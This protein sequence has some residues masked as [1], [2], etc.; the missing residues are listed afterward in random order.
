MGK[1]AGETIAAEIEARSRGESAPRRVFE[2]H[3]KGAMAIIGRN[4]AVAEI[5]RLSFRGYFA[6][7]AWAFIHILFL[8]GFRRKLIVFAEWIWQYLT[9]SRGVRLIT[10][11]N[12]LPRP[13]KPPPDPRR[14]GDGTG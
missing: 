5:G 11:D 10:G 3:D 4:R 2:Y 8:I 7:L 14:T 1:F 12:R 13:V 6:F 9:R